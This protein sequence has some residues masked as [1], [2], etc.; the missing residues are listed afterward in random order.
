[1]KIMKKTKG[2]YLEALTRPDLEFVLACPEQRV[3][4]RE[5]HVRRDGGLRLIR[6]PAYVAGSC[7][8]V[9]I[10]S[11]LPNSRTGTMAGPGVTISAC[12]T[13]ALQHPTSAADATLPALWTAM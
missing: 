8:D 12:G 9:Y 5:L 3:A 13:A 4:G 7:I 6:V 10:L 1:M 11:Q 2:M